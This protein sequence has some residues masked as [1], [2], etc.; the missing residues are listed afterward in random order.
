MVVMLLMVPAP[1][2]FLPSPKVAAR[3]RDES[4]VPSPGHI[5]KRSYWDKAWDFGECGRRFL[6]K[7][8]LKKSKILSS[9][10]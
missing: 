5:Y 8:S 10:A 2:N 7:P 3:A 6:K 4:L 1:R 9:L